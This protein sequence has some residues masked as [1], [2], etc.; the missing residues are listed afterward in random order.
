M[1]V[2]PKNMLD[3]ICCVI[4]VFNKIRSCRRGEENAFCAW[5]EMF[6]MENTE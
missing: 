2:K 6:C 1:I 3:L 4:A 5:F